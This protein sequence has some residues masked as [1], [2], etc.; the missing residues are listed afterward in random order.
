MPELRKDVFGGMKEGRGGGGQTQGGVGE[1]E[2]HKKKRGM[3]EEK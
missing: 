3:E 2:M 1:A